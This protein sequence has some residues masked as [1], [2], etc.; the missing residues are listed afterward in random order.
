MVAYYAVPLKDETGE[1]V[2][3]LEFA[4]DITEQAQYEERLREQNQTIR[5]MST[6]TIKLWD[7]ILVLPVVGVIDSMRAQ[8]MMETMLNRS[9]KPIPGSSS[10]ISRAWPRSTP[11]LQTI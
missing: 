4:V 10:W 3:G 7:G 2:G 1:I 5:L 9:S 6:P 8:N 11:P